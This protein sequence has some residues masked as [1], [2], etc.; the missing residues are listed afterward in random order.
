MDD[1]VLQKQLQEAAVRLKQE[2]K[3]AEEQVEK[4]GEE[5]W[6]WGEGT[7][8][9]G[10]TAEQ[11]W[12]GYSVEQGY[13]VQDA[14]WAPKEEGDDQASSA[15]GARTTIE[16]EK[17]WGVQDATWLAKEESAWDDW[18]SS[19]NSWR[20]S[21]WGA[22]W[23]AKREWQGTKKESWDKPAWAGT[24]S[25]RQGKGKP[26]SGM[27]GEKDQYGGTYVRD[28]YRDAEGTFFPTLCVRLSQ[29]VFLH[30]PTN[31]NF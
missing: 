23:H 30:S 19:W 8:E 13:G 26:A 12:W 28:G 25:Q 24:W 6:P 29:Y 15:R 7:K 22:G 5:P 17:G 10:G 16:D 3:E 1:A 18:G 9:E 21:S 27:E 31:I 4:P 11:G 2:E 20:G 14:T